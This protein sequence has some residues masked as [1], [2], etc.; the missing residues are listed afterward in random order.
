[1]RHRLLIALLLSMSV[2]G[3]AYAQQAT[4]SLEDKLNNPLANLVSVPFQNTLDFG[5]GPDGDGTRYRLN[6]QPV[7]PFSLSPDWNLV[8]RTI[9]PITYQD[10]F[11][12]VSERRFQLGDVNTSLFLSPR[13]DSHGLTWGAGPIISLP[14]ATDGTGTGQWAL[15][16]TVLLIKQDHQWTFGLL[17]N[18]LW[19]LGDS[20]DP[21]VSSMLLQPFVSK[22]L[23]QGYTLGANTE[24]IYDWPTGEWT[25]PVQV[26]LSK[27]TTIGRQ[28]VS[29]QG[30]VRMFVEKPPGGPDWGL[31][32]QMAFPFP[33]T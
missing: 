8:T 26:S 33:K 13:Q 6:I 4:P 5:G 1:M 25:V 11:S 29:F 28:P 12:S 21:E 32:F 16:P 14:T 31:Q 7:V 18:Q 20:S 30:A 17:A 3:A 2:A 23:G 27:L 24:A 19:G 9:V 22:K 10:G 15:G